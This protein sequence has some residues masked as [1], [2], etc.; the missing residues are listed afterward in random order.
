MLFSWLALHVALGWATAL[1]EPGANRKPQPRSVSALHLGDECKR[2]STPQPVNIDLTVWRKGST[3][4]QWSGNITVGN[5]A[6]TFNVV[7]DTGAGFL[8]IG[9]DNCTTCGQHNLYSPS[10]S[11]TFSNRQEIFFGGAGGGTV[12]YVEDQGANCTAVTDTVRMGDR[13]ALQELFLACDTYSEGLR[14]QLPDGIFGLGSDNTTTWGNVTVEPIFWKLVSSGQLPSPQFSFSFVASGHRSGVLTLGGTDP[15]LYYPDTTK[16]IP[17][18]WELSGGRSRWVLDIQ[19]VGVDGQP[20]ANS[21]DSVAV[22]DTGSATIIVPDE[23]TVRALYGRMSD[24]IQLL[25]STDL[26]GAWGAPCAVLDSVARDVTFT[27]GDGDGDGAGAAN[28][29]VAKRFFNVGEYPGRPGICQAVFLHSTIPVREPYQNRSVWLVGTPMLR[30]YYTIWNAVE[31][32]IGFA[33]PVCGGDPDCV[34]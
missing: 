14:V 34:E 13:S 21:S 1:P 11:S 18:D 5:P 22:L 27:V 33:K 6:Q 25:D 19:T 30:S 17:M 2:H 10:A 32:T 7:F 28:L 31:R 8:L 16:T 4:L 26:L 29:T 15:S 23:E 12:P 24:Q 20:L 9:R 3:E